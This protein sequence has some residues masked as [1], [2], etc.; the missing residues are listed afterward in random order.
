MDAYRGTVP[1]ERPRLLD[2]P[3]PTRTRAWF[4]GVSVEDYF[5]HGNAVALVTSR[6]SEGWPSSASW[7]PAAWVSITTVDGRASYWAGSRELPTRDVV[8]IRRGADRYNPIRGVG[9]IEQHLATLDRAGLEEEYERTSL[10]GHGVP[11][12]AIIAPNPLLSQEEADE[13]KVA[14][15]DKYNGPGRE[16]AILPFGTTVTPLGWSPADS[17]M[18]EARKMSLIDVANAFNLD[19]YWLGAEMRGLT[20]RSPGPLYLGLLRTS[21]EPVMADFEQGWADSWLPR[22]QEVRFDRLQLTRDDFG[23]SVDALAKAIAPPMSAPDLGGIMSPTE[24]RLYLGLPAEM[25]DAPTV[26]S[27]VDTTPAEPPATEPPPEPDQGDSNAGAGP[28][29]H[30]AIPSYARPEEVTR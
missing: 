10:T 24:A 5:W 28:T 11:S 16:P 17:Q 27:P 19:G 6:N 9:V 20:Y 21:L 1:L 4:V 30:Y 3:D 14:W 7:I 13:G 15:M 8:H 29:I 26:T 22:G 2:R 23:A 12:V 25:E 18:V